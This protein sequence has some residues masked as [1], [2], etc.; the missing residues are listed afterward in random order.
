MVDATLKKVL[1]LLRPDHA[2][3]V[4]GAAAV[5]L[6]EVGSRD[7][8]VVEALCG[9]L[10]DPEPTVRLP[11]LAAVGQLRLEQALPRLLERVK[12]GGAEADAAAQA[13][14]QLGAKGPKA[15]QDLMP[16]IA[17][18]L[19]RRVAAALGAAGTASAETLAVDAL[20]DRDPGVVEAATRSLVAEVPSLTDAHRAALGKHLLDLLAR[21]KKAPLPPVSETAV[22]RLLAALHDVRAE[23]VFWERTEPSHPPELRAAALQALGT[24]TTAPAK[25][26]LKRLLAC[27]G[28][29]D[30][31]VAAPALLILKAASVTER[32]LPDWLTLLDAPD[33]AVRRL[34]I[35]KLGDRD[36]PAVAAALLRQLD[37]PD[38]ALRGEALTR[39]TRLAS[40]RAALAGTLLD[41]GSADQLWVLARTLAPVVREQGWDSL[42]PVRARAQKY[43]EAG[44]R[45]ADALLSLLRETDPEKLRDELHERA[46]ALRKKKDYATALTYLKLLGRDPACGPAIRLELAGCGL[47]VSG[48]DLAAD[49]RSQDPALQQFASLIHDHGDELTGFVEKSKWL[50]PE[51]LFY[52]GFHFSEQN[53]QEKE[54][55]GQ[56]LQLLVKRSP[57]AKLAKDARS[58]LKRE[59]LT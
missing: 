37:H 32:A 31:R 59:G 5:V 28:D 11:A 24:R 41:S 29:R 30:F 40:G 16:R 56:V 21:S 1:R 6:G 55:G 25:D 45:R 22:V 34:G 39:L 50:E 15:L 27:A 7:A 23:E 49:Q 9:A 13:A 44:D 51:D 12:E 33:V 52:L 18:G 53:R 48:K 2:P 20:L 35:E 4:R 3:E 8:E 38:Q 57:R 47:K 58:K 19:R 14:A 42:E 26:R 43:V 46:L 17:P 10:D 54:F 36:T